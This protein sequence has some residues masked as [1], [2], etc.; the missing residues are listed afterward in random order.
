[1]PFFFFL[2]GF[3]LPIPL[4]FLLWLRLSFLFVLTF[5]DIYIYIY[6]CS[7]LCLSFRMLCVA[8]LCCPFLYNLRAMYLTNI[9]N[10]KFFRSFTNTSACRNIF[11]EWSDLI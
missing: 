5:Y 6:I 9:K 8:L 4:L 10:N 7:C 3:S 11:N 2:V 1:M